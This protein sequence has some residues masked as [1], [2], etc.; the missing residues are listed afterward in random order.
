MDLNY[1]RRMDTE[2]LKT[3]ICSVLRGK[4]NNPEETMLTV[5]YL[6]VLDC[7]PGA[8][9]VIPR[10]R[11][12]QAALETAAAYYGTKR[13][14]EFI[15]LLLYHRSAVSF[16]KE[17]T[18]LMMTFSNGG[19]TACVISPDVSSVCNMAEM[20]GNYVVPDIYDP[21]IS[22]IVRMRLHVLSLVTGENYSAIPT[23]R[24]PCFGDPDR[25]GTFYGYDFVFS[26]YLLSDR[27]YKRINPDFVF[28]KDTEHGLTDSISYEWSVHLKMIQMLSD[29]GRAVA[30]TTT[31]AV[32]NKSE[33]A[34]RKYF[35][36]NGF[37]EKV[38]A[39]PPKLFGYTPIPVFLIVFSRGNETIDFQ[40]ASG[41]FTPA[42]R[43]NR[44]SREDVETISCRLNSEKAAASDVRFEEN[45]FSLNPGDYFPKKTNV[46]NS[47]FLGDIVKEIIRGIQMN[48]A[49][50]DRLEVKEKSAYRYLRISDIQDGLVS[51]SLPYLSSIPEGSEKYRAFKGD[52]IV[53]KTG[54]PAK[55]AVIDS[56]NDG[57]LITGNLYIIRTSRSSVNPYYLTAYLSGNTGQKLLTEISGGSTIKTISVAALRKL[58]VPVQD[59]AVQQETAEKYREKLDEISELRRKL[60]TAVSELKNIYG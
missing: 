41:V 3:D 26:G 28:R 21:E 55:T 56:K 2:F 54:N 20:S 6:V 11:M 5:A 4:V 18:N 38:I 16:P 1:Y 53:A 43:M 19:K 13:E 33:A 23:V 39:L 9:T 17:V 25:Y 40:D 22:D 44:L 45:F 48:A 59:E 31:G 27:P 24:I 34:V 57:I 49:D 51:D 7:C 14:D 32:S 35:I 42:R 29:G 60:S 52:I 50:F 36:E 10:D 12:P 58:P 8:H 47:V 15:S 37:V 46:S 30:V